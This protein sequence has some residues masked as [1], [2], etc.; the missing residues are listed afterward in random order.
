MGIINKVGPIVEGQ[1]FF[2]RV[3]KLDDAWELIKNGHSLILAAPRRV[4][5]SSFSKKM[6][7][8]AKKKRMEYCR[9]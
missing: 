2:G 4:G 5:K 8:I 6:I 1:D 3:K 9:H 7:E